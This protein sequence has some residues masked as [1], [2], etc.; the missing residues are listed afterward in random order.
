MNYKEAEILIVEK[1]LKVIERL[2][3]IIDS[4]GALDQTLEAASMLPAY[5]E[6][7]RRYTGGGK[8]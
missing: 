2:E 4:K 6:I 5:F 8:R 3:G 1:T 7:L